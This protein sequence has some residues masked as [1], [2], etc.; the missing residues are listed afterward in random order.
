MI[1]ALS[2]VPTILPCPSVW[3]NW[4]RRLTKSAHDTKI[5]GISEEYN[6]HTPPSI[7]ALIHQKNKNVFQYSIIKL[8]CYYTLKNTVMASCFRVWSWN[9]RH[10]CSGLGHEAYF[11]R[12][13]EEILNL[14]VVSSSRTLWN[15]V[16]H[17]K[18]AELPWLMEQCRLFN[19]PLSWALANFATR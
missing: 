4:G 3:I 19:V 6:S 17:F 9:S 2:H 13:S 8:L 5:L 14:I 12:I 16:T 1:S 7:T 18:G 15:E 10:S 11:D